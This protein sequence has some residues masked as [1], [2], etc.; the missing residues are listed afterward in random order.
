MAVVRLNMSKNASASGY[1][2]AQNVADDDKAVVVAAWR[3]E[4]A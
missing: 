2:L 3:R 4:I 1:L